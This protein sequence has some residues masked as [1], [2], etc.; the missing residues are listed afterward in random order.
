MS[1]FGGPQDPAAGCSQ[2]CLLDRNCCT[3]LGAE[4][5][6]VS[7]WLGQV[8]QHGDSD[9]NL[10]LCVKVDRPHDRRRAEGLDAC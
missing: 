7:L 3:A 9:N 4:A 1:S 6:L 10:D 5:E 2:V 8:S